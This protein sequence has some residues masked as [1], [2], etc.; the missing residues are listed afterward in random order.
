MNVEGTCFMTPRSVLTQV[1]GSVMEAMFS[2]RHPVKEVDGMVFLKKDAETFKYVLSY[3]TNELK[4]I[5]K[6]DES[7]KK[8]V[9]I[10]L[11]YWGLPTLGYDEK[12]QELQNLFNSEPPF[13]SYG[14]PPAIAVWK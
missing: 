8:L 9:N 4:M 10:E 12:L 11:E 3:L 14:Q 7:E 13:S 1:K 5:R 6:I 2:G